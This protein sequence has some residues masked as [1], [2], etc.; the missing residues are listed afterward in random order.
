[1]TLAE[2]IAA[3]QPLYTSPLAVGLVT[4]L[5]SSVLGS[6]FALRTF[7]HQ[8]RELVDASIAWQWV[9]GNG[10][11]LDEEPFLVV[12]NRSVTPAFIVKARLLR[13][14]IIRTEARGYAFSYEEPTDGSYPLEV[15]AQ[16]VSSF[17]LATYH[18]DKTAARSR[19][20]SRVICYLFRRSYLWIEVT[21]ITGVRLVVPANDATSFQKRPL[22]LSGRW[23]PEPKPDWAVGP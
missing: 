18:T 1:M 9:H 6:Y 7:R 11:K 22:W 23:W 13:G 5:V 8:T 2:I 16:N 19:W 15:K 14:T 10:G 20:Y 12:Q 3:L 17:P 4:V 21:T